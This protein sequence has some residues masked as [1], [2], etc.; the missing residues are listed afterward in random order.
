MRP[1]SDG[2]CTSYCFCAP[3]RF[4]F[5]VRA[6]AGNANIV[7][8]MA[9]DVMLIK[10]RTVMVHLRNP[11]SPPLTAGAT[12]FLYFIQAGDQP[13]EA[14]VFVHSCAVRRGATDR[15]IPEDWGHPEDDRPKNNGLW[16]QTS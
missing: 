13:D 14:G 7:A 6:S 15:H 11:F 1:S 5:L 16:D 10:Q 3:G 9:A 2:A 8:T 12:R 4:C